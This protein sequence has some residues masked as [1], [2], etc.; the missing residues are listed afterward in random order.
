MKTTQITVFYILLLAIASNIPVAFATGLPELTKGALAAG[1]LKPSPSLVVLEKASPGTIDTMAKSISGEEKTHVAAILSV[2]KDLCNDLL[3]LG[4]TGSMTSSQIRYERDKICQ[5]LVMGSGE[6]LKNLPLAHKMIGIVGKILREKEWALTMGLSAS[7]GKAGNVNSEVVKRLESMKSKCWSTQN[8]CLIGQEMAKLEPVRR[9]WQEK[10]DNGADQVTKHLEIEAMS[11]KG[12][13]DMINDGVK[14]RLLQSRRYLIEMDL[15]E[16]DMKEVM[17]TFNPDI[18]KF[19]TE[20]KVAFELKNEITNIFEKINNVI[21]NSRSFSNQKITEFLGGK[22]LNLERAKMNCEAKF[23]KGQCIQMG[24]VAYCFKC[25]EGETV[26][27]DTISTCSCKKSEGNNGKKLGFFGF[28]HSTVK[29][30]KK[31][32]FDGDLE[33]IFKHLGEIMMKFMDTLK[34]S[35]AFFYQ[36]E[37]GYEDKVGK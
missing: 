24:L 18:S 25:Q 17:Q 20:Q 14:K 8:N 27:W 22:K 7:I 33:D 11:Q 4:S 34:V 35:D 31:I 1:L 30:I 5:R 36:V 9:T 19:T 32:N 3:R 2:Y 21:R 6:A 26:F 12:M 10:R 28:F 16:K 23:G 29:K 37:H 13:T 15:S